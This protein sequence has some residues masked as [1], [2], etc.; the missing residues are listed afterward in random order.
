MNPMVSQR[1]AAVLCDCRLERKKMRTHMLVLYSAFWHVK[2]STTTSTEMLLIL[3]FRLAEL[4]W[5]LT[6]SVD[7]RIWCGCVVD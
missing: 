4:R 3:L 7:A 6:S 1:V 2:D 5:W